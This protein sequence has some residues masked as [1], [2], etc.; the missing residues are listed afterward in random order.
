MSWTWGDCGRGAW[1]PRPPV[2]GRAPPAPPASGRQT[3]VCSDG[4]GKNGAQSLRLMRKML[5]LGD[6]TVLRPGPRGDWQ[7]EE[8]RQGGKEGRGRVPQGLSTCSPQHLP[9]LAGAGALRAGQAPPWPPRPPPGSCAPQ[10]HPQHLFQLLSFLLAQG[11]LRPHRLLAGQEP[12]WDGQLGA[13]CSRLA[14]RWSNGAMMGWPGWQKEGPRSRWGGRERKQE[15]GCFQ[16]SP[17]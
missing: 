14:E 16:V 2:H 15:S 8:R 6:K 11:H 7:G 12:G 17:A 1:W 9:T 5:Y 10:D 4:C 13:R 3:A